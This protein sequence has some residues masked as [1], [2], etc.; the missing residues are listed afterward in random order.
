MSEIS[1][2]NL[3][4]LGTVPVRIKVTLQDIYNG[5]PKHSECCPIALACKRIFAS[6]AVDV[7][8]EIVVDNVYKFSLPKE[9]ERFIVNFDKGDDNAVPF[10]FDVEI[11]EDEEYWE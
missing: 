3:S 10:E 4:D 1:K 8:D 11:K 5:V 9:A 6:A 2:I 7:S